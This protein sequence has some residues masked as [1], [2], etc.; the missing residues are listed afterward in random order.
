M[1]SLL[2]LCPSL[3][4]HVKEPYGKSMASEPDRMSNLFFIPLAHLC[5]V[6]CINCDAIKPRWS[7]IANHGYS[8]KISLSLSK[9][10][11]GVYFF[12]P[13]SFKFPQENYILF[14]KM[15]ECLQLE[16]GIKSTSPNCVSCI[17][18]VSV[19]YSTGCRETT[20]RRLKELIATL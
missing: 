4:G 19:L 12:T 20:R 10:Q 18:S 14:S 13:T 6:T 8:N 17:I 9:R 16:N 15:N 2:A 5:A 7:W 11:C 1:S 3:G